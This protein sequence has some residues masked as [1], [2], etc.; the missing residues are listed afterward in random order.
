LK[1]AFALVDACGFDAVDQREELPL[2]LE[3]LRACLAEA[4]VGVGELLHVWELLGQRG[5][6]LRL[7]LAA[8]GEHGAGV[9]FTLGAA[10]VGFSTAAAEGVEG[11]REERL[12]AEEGLEEG[13]ELLLAGV[14]LGAEG[15]EVL[16]H[17]IVLREPVWMGAVCILLYILHLQ[18]SRP[19]GKKFRGGEKSRIWAVRGESLRPSGVGGERRAIGGPGAAE[20]VFSRS[21][22]QTAA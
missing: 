20:R 2:E 12:T 8:I 19:R 5:E 9:E 18:I 15:A 17:G 10:A 1:L 21:E 13:V 7:A 3:Q 14:E 11:A 16:G 6:V 22:A 4:S